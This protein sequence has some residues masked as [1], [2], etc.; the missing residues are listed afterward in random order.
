MGMILDDHLTFRKHVKEA[1]DNANKG[2][3]LMKYLSKYVDR[4]TLDQTY[5]MY[6]RPRLDYGDVIFMAS[7]S[8]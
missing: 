1:I 8:I 2:I 6:V 4:K 7:L 3:S 5:K